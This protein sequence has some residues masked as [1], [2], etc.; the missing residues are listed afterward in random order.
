MALE[1]YFPRGCRSKFA[2]LQEKVHLKRGVPFFFV[3]SKRIFMTLDGEGI[4][5][6]RPAQDT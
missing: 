3:F 5:G 2:G 1:V 4:D 6:K